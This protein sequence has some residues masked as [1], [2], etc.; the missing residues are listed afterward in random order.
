MDVKGNSYILVDT[1][2]THIY[3]VMPQLQTIYNYSTLNNLSYNF[4]MGDQYSLFSYYALQGCCELAI[5]A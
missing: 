2:V 4:N 1:Y 3:L 5:A